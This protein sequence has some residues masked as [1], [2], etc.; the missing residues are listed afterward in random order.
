MVSWCPNDK[1][2][3]NINYF[4]A[5]GIVDFNRYAYETILLQCHCRVLVN[6]YYS[7]IDGK[8]KLEYEVTLTLY[9]EEH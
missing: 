7:V 1:K 8:K 3:K 5:V 4:L 9:F 2:R 6:H